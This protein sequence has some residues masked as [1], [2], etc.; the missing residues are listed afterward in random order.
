MQHLDLVGNVDFA[1]LLPSGLILEESLWAKIIV[2][3]LLLL[4]LPAPDLLPPF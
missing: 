3:V 4:F 1:Y 2:V